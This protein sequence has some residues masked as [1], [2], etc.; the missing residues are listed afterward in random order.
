[1][2][3]GLE[4]VIEPTRIVRTG[5]EPVQIRVMSAI[6]CVTW[7]EAWAGHETAR[8]GSRGLP[9]IGQEEFLRNKR[10]EG[11]LKDLA[12]V[13]ALEGCGGSSISREADWPAR[14]PG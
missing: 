9:F 11:R 1:V 13:E 5:A 10:L 12:H 3:L 6:S 8:R 14:R 7:D 4:Q 2:N